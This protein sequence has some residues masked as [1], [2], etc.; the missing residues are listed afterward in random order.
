MDSIVNK[1]V[2]L[3]VPGLVLLVAM[4]IVG[5]SGAAAITTS[6]AL[7]GGPIGMIG[8]IG[9]LVLLGLIANAISEYGMERVYRAVLAGLREKGLTKQ[10]IL[11]TIEGYP[12]TRGL[13]AKL[14]EYIRQQPGDDRS[15]DDLLRF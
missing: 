8:G 11:N 14:K 9:L 6:L 12:I 15:D 10:D 5:W 1:I 2:A 13:K 3:G 4:G 7:L